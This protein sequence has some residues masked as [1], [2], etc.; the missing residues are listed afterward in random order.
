MRVFALSG[1]LRTESWNTKLLRLAV[2]L[3]Q[4]R[5]VEV[6]LFDFR[7]AQI[8]IYDPDTS[9]TNPAPQVLD[10]KERIRKAHGLFLVSPEY[11]NSVPGALKNFID[12]VSRPA[13]DHPFG[14]KLVAHLGATPGGFGTLYSQAA[15]RQ[16]FHALRAWSLPGHFVVSNAPTAFTADGKLADPKRQAELER[17]VGHYVDELRRFST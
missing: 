4:A 3:L 12:Y 17:F 5:G 13:K 8:P 6:D 1:S 10:A 11:N 16:I 2:P 14:G 9:D 15:I 7:A